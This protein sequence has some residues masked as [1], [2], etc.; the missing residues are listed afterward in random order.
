MVWGN[1]DC[2]P[3]QEKNMY[4]SIKISYNQSVLSNPYYACHFAS[5]THL[6]QDK[7][8]TIFQTSYLNAY[9]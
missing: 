4:D 9:S 7:M 8:A 2:L 3:F 6:G 5:L 1:S